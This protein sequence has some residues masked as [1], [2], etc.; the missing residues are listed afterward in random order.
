MKHW[1]LVI[2]ILLC[3]IQVTPQSLKIEDGEVQLCRDCGNDNNGKK[4]SKFIVSAQDIGIDKIRFKGSLIVEQKNEGDKK[5]VTFLPNKG[6]QITISATY[7]DTIITLPNDI[8]GGVEYHI[9]IIFVPDTFYTIKY[10]KYIDIPDS[11]KAYK[12]V[13]FSIHKRRGWKFDSLSFSKNKIQ[14]DF[15]NETYMGSF[16]MPKFD[17]EIETPHYSRTFIGQIVNAIINPGG[18]AWKRNRKSVYAGF[19]V[20][21]AL[22][23][24]GTNA[25][26]PSYYFGYEYRLLEPVSFCV[27]FQQSVVYG[28]NNEL[29]N[30]NGKNFKTNLLEYGLNVS[31]YYIKQK[32]ISRFGNFQS[33]SQWKQSIASYLSF[34][35]ALLHF[36]PKG[37]FDGKWIKL[38]QF[39]TEGQGTGYTSTFYDNHGNI[40]QWKADKKYKLTTPTY[41]VGLGVKYR[42]NPKM[43]IIAEISYHFANTDYLDD[44]HSDYYF[45]YQ[46][47][48]IIS[49]N[50]LVEKNNIYRVDNIGSTNIKTLINNQNHQLGEFGRG[51][52]KNNDKFFSVLFTFYFL[53]IANFLPSRKPQYN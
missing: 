24:I 40:H 37:K 23:D 52:S 12:K 25:L 47:A 45:N 41:V 30:D 39:N 50:T 13:Y 43:G 27:H 48:G 21:K 4:M 26:F 42:L 51:N 53:P 44:I 19:G 7:C 31:Y 8:R 28:M 38:Q 3:A 49:D 2:G 17:L 10:D 33:V 46:D 32:A 22:F 9:T 1:L 15:D 29:P 6:Q 34:G 11:S 16:E 14:Y 5:I 20:T 18:S 35:F 36:N